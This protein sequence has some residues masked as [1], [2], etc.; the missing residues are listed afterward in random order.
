MNKLKT[1]SLMAGNDSLSSL[2]EFMKRG[3]GEGAHRREIRLIESNAKCGHLKKLTC[4]GTMR[5]VYIYMSGS[6]NL[7]PLPPYTLYTCIQYTYSHREEGRG[8]I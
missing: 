6:Q 3:R 4:K 2:L 7:I 1:V 5:Q 8:E